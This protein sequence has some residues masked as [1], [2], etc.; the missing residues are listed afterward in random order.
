VNFLQ[1]KPLAEGFIFE[2]SFQQPSGLITGFRAVGGL[3]IRILRELRNYRSAFF[4]KL[5]DDE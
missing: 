2:L 5:I 3:I 4:V 1:G